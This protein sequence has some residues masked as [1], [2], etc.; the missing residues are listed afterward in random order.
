MGDVPWEVFTVQYDGEKPRDNI[1]S[2][3]T[4][5]FNV[6]YRDPRLVV[7]NLLSNADFRDGIDYAPFKESDASEQRVYGDFMSGDWVWEKAVCPFIK[8]VRSIH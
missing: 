3:M 7:K 2:W 6:W 8:C 5:E 4:A 1:P